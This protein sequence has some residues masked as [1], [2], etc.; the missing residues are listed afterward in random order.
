LRGT[1]PCGSSTKGT[2]A[3]GDSRVRKY[4]CIA[5]LGILLSGSGLG[6]SI[7]KATPFIAQ[8]DARINIEVINHGFEDA[9]LHAMWTGKRVRLGTV[10]GTR[11]AT[12]MLPWAVP[13]AL[14][15]EIDLLA[16]VACTTRPIV[17]DPGDI[18]LVEI[19]QDLRNC[20]YGF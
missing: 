16:S 1:R 18:I 3:E 17:A 15:I 13:Y 4:V 7:T 5:V 9:T 6:C 11:T 20:G 19:R 8:E 2:Q 14:Q 12:F 10:S